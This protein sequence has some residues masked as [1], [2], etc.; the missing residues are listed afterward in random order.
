VG[1]VEVPRGILFHAYDYNGDGRIASAD[2][3]IPTNQNHANIQGDFNALAPML[4]G[5][6]PEEIELKLSM[7]VRGYDPCI[8]CS[9]HM[10]DM[11]PGRPE[12]GVIFKQRKE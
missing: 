8:S 5:K 9:T 10:L 3:V 11:Q 4:S 6:D 1:A 2:C 12:G 7:L